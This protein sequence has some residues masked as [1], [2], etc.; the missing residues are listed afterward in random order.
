M[1]SQKSVLLMTV[2]CLRA[3]HVGF[4]GYQ[5]PTSPFLDSLAAGSFVFPAAIVAGAP[6]YYSL[7]AILASRYPLAYGRDLI[8][9]SPEE[10]TLASVFQQAGYQTAC[11]SAANPYISSRFGYDNGFDTFNDFLEVEP[12]TPSESKPQFGNN[13]WANALNRRLRESSHRLG[14]LGS[15]YEE[16][17]FQ[18]CQRLATPAP[19]SLDRLRRFPA[20]NVVVDHACAWLAS[21]EQRPFFLWLHFMDPHSP[22]YPTE[23]AFDLM[24]S[25]QITAFRARYLNSS[26]NRSDLGPSRLM[27]H[28][29]DILALYDAAI[30]FVD[31]QVAR[32]IESLK[33]MRR[34]DDCILG[35]TADHGEEF[36]DHGGRYHPPSSLGEELVRV[37]LLLHVPG[38]GKRELSIS[39]FSLLHLAPTLLDAAGMSIPVAFRGR[40]QWGELLEGRMTH[41]VAI[42]ESV[43]S[44]TNP[45]RSQNRV[46]PRLLAV[47]ERRFKLL[48]HFDPSA[49]YLYDLETDPSETRPLPQSA[50]RSTRRRLL[51]AA[52][53]HLQ[54]SVSDRNPIARLSSRLRELR[55]EWTKPAGKIAP[56]SL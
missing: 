3:D 21:I 9:L 42:V 11:F 46:G 20:A 34:W 18:Y 55:L 2:D 45:F 31:A 24:G 28:R 8:G 27:H 54:R 30:R 35:L 48:L 40:S 15:L 52:H 10:P 41:E 4:M 32:L 19:G 16:L 43:A 13:G 25:P 39:P 51:E 7:P 14:P 47:R 50:E 53:Q 49:E 44:C 22:Y 38:V 33:S 5:R 36:L 23:K 6:T 17:Y 26:W 37:P 12:L 1:G 56:V 29:N